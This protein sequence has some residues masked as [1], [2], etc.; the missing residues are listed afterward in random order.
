M[1][2]VAMYLFLWLIVGLTVVGFGRYVYGRFVSRPVKEEPTAAV[3]GKAAAAVTETAPTKEP[4]P[5]PVASGRAAPSPARYVPP[6]PPSRKRLGSRTGRQ[7]PGPVVIAARGKSAAAAVGPPPP[8]ATGPDSVSV[9]WVTE[10]FAW[11]YS[12]L[13]VVNEALAI[14]LQSLNEFTKKSVAEHG[15]GVEFVRVLPETSVPS[16]N[17][18]F[19]ECAPN[20]DVTITCDCEA[21]PA[22]QLKVFRQKGEKIEVSHYRLNVNRF[23]A[24]LNVNA[25]SEKLLFDI[26]CDGWPEVKVALAPV[27]AIKNNLDESQL[28]E[29]I[30]EIVTAALRSTDVHCNFSNYPNCP[31][32]S[33]YASSPGHM[34][35]VHYDS[36]VSIPFFKII[37]QIK[38]RFIRSGVLRAFFQI[39]IGIFSSNFT[40]K[41]SPQLSGA[42]EAA[43]QNRRLLVKVIK[44]QG[45]GGTDACIEPF[46]VVE[47]DDPSQKN[48]TSTKKATDNPVWEEH[49]LFDLNNM[50]SEILLEVYDK[51]GVETRFL[52]LGI[53]SMDELNTT[54]SQRQTISL[55]STPGGEEVVSGSLTVE[56]TAWNAFDKSYLNSIE[57]YFPAGNPPQPQP[58]SDQSASTDASETGELECRH[59]QVLHR[60][61]HLRWKNIDMSEGNID[62]S[63]LSMVIPNITGP[64]QVF[65]LVQPALKLRHYNDY[66][67]R[68]ERGRSRRKK[69][70]FFGTLRRF[71]RSKTRSRSVGPGT[72]EDAEY[73]AAVAR[74]ISADRARD[75]SAHSAVP[76]M[77][78]GSAR[79]SLSEASGISGASS[80][81]YVNEASTLVLETVENCIKKYYLV[82]L[83]IAQRNKW[84]KK[85]TKLHIYN[86]HTFI[87][88]HLPG[89]TICQVCKKGLPR[90][91]GKQGYEC[92]DCQHKCHKH[93]H[94]K[95]E[96]TCPN[97]NIHSLE[98][99]FSLILSLLNSATAVNEQSR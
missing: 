40:I 43:K 68:L 41:L 23:R 67:V 7:S 99:D 19:C 28:Q 25:I 57:K 32:M 37:F 87:A 16:I 50:T 49:F 63:I 5:K 38:N 76:G 53:V 81:T 79:S 92:R 51:R 95:V 85:G 35:P 75:P 84:K 14:W 46:C 30:S 89:G 82:P 83:S 91:L 97:S 58:A 72:E 26:K 2:T 39:S 69:R 36:I 6:T 42:E 27:G 24:R 71:G 31:R 96:T 61:L 70:D 52:G 22:L 20:D 9:K 18:V 13:V 45:L 33:R 8:S 54:P 4:T 66:Y 74:S 34:L 60:P 62:I 86:D 64:L 15:V 29:V 1:D 3:D 94:V 80:R 65:L 59:F 11:L 47:V 12:D 88:K 55:Q 10:M 44:A 56:T 21:T 77:R 93:C 17:N 48:Q 78:E 98:L 90:R 73:N